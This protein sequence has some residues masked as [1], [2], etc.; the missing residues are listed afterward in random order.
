MGRRI[1][2]D[3][4][5]ELYRK[6]RELHK[7]GLSYRNI[8]R[9][10]EEQYGVRIGKSHISYWVRGIH[11]PEREPYNKPDFSKEE[12]AWIAGMY[13]GDGSIKVNKEGRTLTLKVRD[14][15]L[16]EEAAR[17]LAIVMG[18]DKP[19]FVG[20]LS[21]GRYY[22]EVRS[23]ELADHLFKRENVLGYLGKWPREFIRAFFDC[24]G[25]VAGSIS[26]KGVFLSRVGASNTDHD[27]LV[28]IRDKLMDL[29][30]GTRIIRTFS[31]GRIVVTSKGRAT[32]RKD[33]YM[34]YTT[35]SGDLIEFHSKIGF[36]I[37]RKMEKL[38]DI[39]YILENFKGRGAAIEWIRRYEYRRGEGRERWF[40][41][42]SPLSQEDA[43]EE[44]EKFLSSRN[45]GISSS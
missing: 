2:H 44:Y 17:K 26:R 4:R 7:Q 45:R 40:K 31:A 18:R 30:I 14:R 39:V 25:F 23:R 33:C 5:L 32:A 36:S 24:E 6:V 12:M 1:H 8:Q 19:Y 15:E 9:I 41:R 16:V 28:M 35:R 29:G 13:V 43:L 42:K 10:I 21:D 37:P 11:T 3:L 20:K 34:L 22:V 38:R 27:L